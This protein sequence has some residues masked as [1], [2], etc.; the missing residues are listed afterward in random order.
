[1]PASLAA[2]E[3]RAQAKRLG[4][5][6]AQRDNVAE[7]M[8]AKVNLARQRDGN[9]AYTPRHFAKLLKP[10]TY[11]CRTP[12]QR[13]QRLCWL[14]AECSEAEKRGLPHAAVF[15][16]RTREARKPEQLKLLEPT[17]T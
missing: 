11:R 3:F 12:E 10:I 14:E 4:G 9:P 5:P 17:N 13:L 6:R 1:M 15:H 16:L 2:R 7:R 8:R